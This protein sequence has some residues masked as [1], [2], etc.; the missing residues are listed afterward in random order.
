VL[1]SVAEVKVTLSMAMKGSAMNADSAGLLAALLYWGC[2]S[3][4]GR[5]R[6]RLQQVHPKPV[7]NWGWRIS[8]RAIWTPAKQNLQKRQTAAPD[9][10]RTQ[11]GMALYEQRTGDQNSCRTAVISRRSSWLRNNGTVLK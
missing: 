6:R 9:D 2:S 11:L 10:Y 8:L 4:S 3:S 7:L 5:E 1:L